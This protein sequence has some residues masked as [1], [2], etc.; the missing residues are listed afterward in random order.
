MSHALDY[1]RW[2]ADC[3]LAARLDD[4]ALANREEHLDY[5]MTAALEAVASVPADV[6]R[7]FA[8]SVRA[9]VLARRLELRELEREQHTVIEAYIEQ[10]RAES[11]LRRVA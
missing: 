7:D 4:I 6:A 9:A 1:D 3:V 2:R 10:Q 8:R 5:Y 11:R